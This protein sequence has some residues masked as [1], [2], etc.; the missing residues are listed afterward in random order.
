M[1][2]FCVRE[3]YDYEIAFLEGLPTKILAHSTN[4]K[5]KKYA[6]V[7]IDLVNHPDSVAYFK[8]E[9]NEAEAYRKFD[10]IVCVSENV[11]QAFSQKYG[12]ANDQ[13]VT[14]YNILENEEILNQSMQDAVLPGISKPCFISVGRLTGQKGYDRLLRVHN[15]L[16]KENLA[17]T[18]VIVGDGELRNQL[19][20]YVKDNDLNDSVFFLGFQ[21]NPHKYVSKADCFVCAS[22]A[23]GFST[24]VSEAVICGIPVISTDV[25]G[26]REPYA[27]PRCSVVVD[28]SEE[29]LY[30]GMKQ[31]LLAPQL[32]N[33]YR[34]RLEECQKYLK[35]E[36]LVDMFERT[37]FEE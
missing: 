28:N 19:E 8:T 4:V 26:S 24:V 25:A 36:N 23:E 1:Y 18:V 7:H 9:S 22:Y 11:A 3:N 32:L 21:K 14:V 10:K 2:R 17:H 34:E 6:W 27:A 33:V 16:I 37:V 5:A 20:Q 30:E 12:E 31:I 35:T 15:R 13:V 29:G